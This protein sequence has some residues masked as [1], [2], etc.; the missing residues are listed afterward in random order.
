MSAPGYAAV[1][2]LFDVFYL[3]IFNRFDYGQCVGLC[4]MAI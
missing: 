1:L 3:L 2:M 4:F